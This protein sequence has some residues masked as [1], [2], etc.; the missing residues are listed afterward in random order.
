MQSDESLILHLQKIGKMRHLAF[1]YQVKALYQNSVVYNYKPERLAEVLKTTPN[2]I[3]KHIRELKKLGFVVKQKVGRYRGNLHFV[4]IKQVIKNILNKNQSH[5]C[6]VRLD[7]TYSIVDITDILLNKVLQFFS[8]QQKIRYENTSELK[9]K[10]LTRSIDISLLGRNNEK[11]KFSELYKSTDRS[12]LVVWG[13]RGIASKLGVS[14]SYIHGVVKRLV[15]KGLLSIMDI[16]FVISNEPKDFKEVTE[17]FE[18]QGFV[19]RKNNRLYLHKGTYYNFLDYPIEMNVIQ[20]ERVSIQRSR[21][22][23][24]KNLLNIPPK[25]AKDLDISLLNIFN[26]SVKVYDN[27]WTK[28]QKQDYMIEKTYKRKKEKEQLEN[29]RYR[30][31]NNIILKDE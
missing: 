24:I 29:E 26:K 13:Y 17:I 27:T 20:D 6:S 10:K 31:I 2:K 21:K 14:A 5:K 4:S 8:R 23:I 16:T 28:K 18:N 1:Y 3:R 19:Y 7:N 30:S 11:D 22:K 25:P 15:S 9:T 12:H